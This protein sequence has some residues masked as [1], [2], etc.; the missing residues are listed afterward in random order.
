MKALSRVSWFD[1][2]HL[3]PHHFQTQ[4]RYFEDSMQFAT[5]SLWRHSYGLLASKIDVDALAHGTVSLNLA[6]GI[7][8]DGLLFQMPE[9]DALP[10]SR[11][12]AEIFPPTRDSLVVMLAVP[13]QKRDGPNC[14]MSL[15]DVDKPLRFT[16]ESFSLTDENTGGDELPV[17]LG[18]KNIR[19]L[20][21]TEPVQEF[22]VLPIARILRSHTGQF[23]LDPSYIPPC[24]QISASARIIWLLDRLTDIME[25]KSQSLVAPREK[26]EA[27]SSYSTK[28]IASFWFLHT[29][30]CSLNI[31]RHE[32][33][34]KHGHPEQVYLELLRLAGAL[35][36]F[37]LDA[38]PRRLPAY[39]HANLGQ[40]YALLDQHI[41]QHLEMIIR[42]NCIAVPLK[43]MQDYFFGGSIPDSRCF[44]PSRWILSIRASMGHAELSARAPELVKVCSQKFIQE[45]VRRGVPGLAVTHVPV[46]PAAISARVETQYFELNKSGGC[47]T[48]IQDTKGFGVYIPGEFPSPEIELLVVLDD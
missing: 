23:V 12:I 22:T 39:D 29:V 13:I 41:R 1:G 4:N 20:M 38:H 5:L 47:W 27:S 46:P 17:Q 33:H 44:G 16:A 45:L 31:L 8:P 3:A 7:F 11:Q 25:V 32:L 26:A 14:A 15:S 28:D 24:L 36:T 30:N 18:R 40:C 37:A 6:R 19:L 35:C 9:C 10:E 21:D 2:M 43:R 48:N 42:T 34:S